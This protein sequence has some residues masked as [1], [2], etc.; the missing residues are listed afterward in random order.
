M[1]GACL[2][3][4]KVEVSEVNKLAG[5]MADI[6]FRVQRETGYTFT[7]EEAYSAMSLTVREAEISGKGDGYVPILL[8]KELRG[9]AMR[10]QIDCVGRVAKCVKCVTAAHA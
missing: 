3:L 6:L 8:E 5:E 4:M 1:I 10:K 2:L 9:L 7:V